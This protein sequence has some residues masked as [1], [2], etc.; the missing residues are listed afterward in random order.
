M[1]ID[2]AGKLTTKENVN[3][4]MKSIVRFLGLAIKVALL[5]LCFL[6]V[7]LLIMVFIRIGWLVMFTSAK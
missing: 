1:F 5:F 3:K 7:V 2:T 4:K 6:I